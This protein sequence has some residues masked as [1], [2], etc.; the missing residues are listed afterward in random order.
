M[1][2]FPHRPAPKPYIT[3]Q[4][5]IKLSMPS[6]QEFVAMAALWR[7]EWM[8]TLTG[9]PADY[10]TLVRDLSDQAIASLDFGSFQHEGVVYVYVKGYQF[11]PNDQGVRLEAGEWVDL[12]GAPLKISDQLRKRLDMTRQLFDSDP[13][14]QT[15]ARA[16]IDACKAAYATIPKLRARRSPVD[17]SE[18]A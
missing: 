12:D 18:A 14:S 6:D 1:N 4:G 15:G 10:P 3:E 16:F 2:P 17:V 11:D 5:P 7:R 8:A 13:H 9:D